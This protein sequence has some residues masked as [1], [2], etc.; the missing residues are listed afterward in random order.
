MRRIP[1]RSLLTL[2]C[3][4]YTGA[5]NSVA[6]KMAL[7]TS[8]NVPA[9]SRLAAVHF[10]SSMRQPTANSYGGIFLIVGHVEPVL[11]LSQ[12]L[13]IIA[14][15]VVCGPLAGFSFSNTFSVDVWLPFDPVPLIIES[16][17]PIALYASITSGVV[18]ATAAMH[19]VDAPV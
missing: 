4:S 11:S 12:S 18:T 14:S 10:S 3:N 5:A 17:Q 8:L 2:V 15:Q 9:R 1:Q 13:G 6:P 19:L 16:G 7:I